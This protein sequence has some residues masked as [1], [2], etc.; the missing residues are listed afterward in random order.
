MRDSHRGE[1]DA[2]RFAA[3]DDFGLSSDLQRHLVVRQSRTGE[4]RELLAADQGVQAID[5]RDAR[6]DELCRVLA[7]IWVNRGARDLDPFL[8]DDRRAAVDR[9]ARAAEDAAEHLPRHVQFDRFPEELHRGLTID[10]GSPL[11]HL[12]DDDVLRRIEDLPSLPRSVWEADFDELSVS[13]PLR[14]LNKDQ[15][16]PISVIVRYSVGISG[17]PQSLEL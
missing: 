4:Q 5:R 3:P 10:P 2:E 17:G 9:L 13:D 6:L 15:R 14:L 16:P 12:H 11:E 1:D 7:G 8:G